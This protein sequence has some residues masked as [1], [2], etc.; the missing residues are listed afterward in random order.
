MK[1]DGFHF[2]LKMT[3]PNQSFTLGNNY[4]PFVSEEGS[5]D[6][7]GKKDNNKSLTLTKILLQRFGKQ[8]LGNNF[9]TKEEFPTQPMG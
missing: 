2:S 7:T 6:Q 5:T 3:D 8:K 4:L 1:H 9:F